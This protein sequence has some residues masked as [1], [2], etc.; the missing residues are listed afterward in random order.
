MFIFE[1]LIYVFFAYMMYNYAKKSYALS[2]RT[3]DVEKP[4][5]NLWRFWLFFALI[6]G[7]RWNVGSDSV[8]YMIVFRDGRIRE[9]SVEHLWNFL[10]Q[11]IHGLDLHY[12]IGMAITGF[13]QIY[14]TTKLT[15]K[16]RYILIFFPIVLF[17]GVYFIGWCNAVRQMMAASIFVYSIQ[18]ILNKKFIPYVMCIFAATQI[19]HSAQVLYVMYVFAYIRP[20][21]IS[22][23]DKKILTTSIFIVCFVLGMT[24]QFQNFLGLFFFLVESLGTYDYVGNVIQQTIVE[25]EMSERNFGPMQLSYFLTALAPIWFGSELKR[26]YK[27]KVPYF[28]LWWFFSYIYS[29]G[30]F[31]VCNVQF[32]FIRPF[33]YFQPFQLII[34]SLLLYYFYCNKLR[35]KFWGYVGVI[36]LSTAWNIM[37]NMD[38][39][40]ESVTYKLFLFHNLDDWDKLFQ[41]AIQ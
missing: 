39:P 12:T 21:K 14:F 6:C 24:P 37:K 5:N 41:Q 33:L 9:E 29:C 8:G 4:D 35:T 17:G 15:S 1:I 11:S 34:N 3:G 7:I 23:S 10:V 31:L 13:V 36:W 27:D 40:I 2:L 38:N 32:M 25:G 28:D 18:Y 20:D 22:I 19:H 26:E 30:Y 16:Y